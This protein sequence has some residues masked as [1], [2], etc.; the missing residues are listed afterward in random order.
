M[1][2]FLHTERVRI[3][4]LTVLGGKA[5][6]YDAMLYIRHKLQREMLSGTRSIDP[7]QI[8]EVSRLNSKLEASSQEIHAV[9]VHVSN[10][11]K[12]LKAILRL[13]LYR[14]MTNIRSGNDVTP[15]INV[16]QHTILESLPHHLY[17]CRLCNSVIAH[18]YQINVALSIYQLTGLALYAVGRTIVILKRL[19]TSIYMYRHPVYTVLYERIKHYTLFQLCPL[20]R[21]VSILRARIEKWNLCF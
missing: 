6:S 15:I 7:E 21:S 14:W 12:V 3:M 4:I 16:W 9:H 19:Y 20:R 8:P 11:H 17:G 18:I 1:K 13:D 5:N 10:I 2:K